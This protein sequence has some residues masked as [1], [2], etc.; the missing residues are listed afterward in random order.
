M[1]EEVAKKWVAAL[2]SGD[3]KQCKENMC[4]TTGNG[5]L[6]YC[7]LGVL[8]TLYTGYREARRDEHGCDFLPLDTMKWAGMKSKRGDRGVEVNLAHLNDA[9]ASFAEIADIIEKEWETL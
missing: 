5:G 6:A 8:D 7:C 9:G 1:K 4:V 3:Y 2:R